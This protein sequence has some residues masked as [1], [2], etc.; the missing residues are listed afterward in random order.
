[1]LWLSLPIGPGFRTRGMAAG[2]KLRASVTRSWERSGGA[3]I[4][5]LGV[6]AGELFPD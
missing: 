3:S 4:E 1:L 6:I 2:K 5:V